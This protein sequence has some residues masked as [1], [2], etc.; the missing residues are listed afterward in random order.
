MHANIYI[1][2]MSCVYIY[3]VEMPGLCRER[4]LNVKFSWAGNSDPSHL[5]KLTNR[6]LN[7]DVNFDLSSSSPLNV[8]CIKSWGWDPTTLQFSQV[9]HIL[10]IYYTYTCIYIYTHLCIHMYMCI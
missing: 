9:C 8:R 3:K 7:G 1:Y 2:R 4:Q 6:K 5:P 10:H